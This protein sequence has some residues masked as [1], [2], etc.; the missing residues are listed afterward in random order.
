MSITR[1][2][3]L[4]TSGAAGLAAG[5]VAPTVHA[6]S[7]AAPKHKT[8][9]IGTGWWGMNILREAVKSGQCQVA[10]MCDVDRAQLEPAVSEIEGMT[11]DKP[12]RYQDWRELL[13]E[14][15]PEIVIVGTPDH[16][17]PLIT[18][19][20]VKNGA[21]V[22]VEKPVGHTIREGRAMVQAARDTG[23]VVQVGTHRRVS[24]HNVAGMKFLKEGKAGK[25]GMVRCFVHYGGGAEEPRANEEPPEGLNWDLWCGPAPLRPFNRKIHP[26]GFRDF[27]DYANGT[28]GDWGIHWMDQVLWWTDE[29]APRTVYSTGGR[30]VAG[31]AIND[32]KRQTSNAPDHQIASFEFEGFSVSWEHRKFGGNAAEKTHPEQ[33]VGCYFYGTEGTFHMGWLDGFTFYPANAKKAPIH[34][35]AQLHE[36]DAQNIRELFANFLECIRS[37]DRPVSDIEI[38]HRSTTMSLLGMLSLKLDR[39]IRWDAE[40]ELVLGDDEANGLLKREYRGEW[41]YPGV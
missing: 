21:H 19:A 16:W 2:D 13:D 20:A 27:L 10:A 1:R 38:G 17:H 37:G 22:Y 5:L 8:A 39:S 40:K 28:L 24:P 15:K 30:Q 29:K 33:A 36:P 14:Q 23:K 31:A 41:K 7:K 18:I 32:G 6:A 34:M 25:I 4:R 9:L 35:D 12:K 3:F 11:P 26:K